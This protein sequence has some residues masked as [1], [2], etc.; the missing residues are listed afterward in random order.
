MAA[1]LR[2]RKKRATQDALS[3]AALDLALQKGFDAVT[4]EAI[5]ELAGVSTRT[6]HN[7]FSSKEAAVL[8]VLN[9]SIAEAIAMFVLRSPDEP[10]LDSMEAMQIN[11]VGSADGLER[12]VAVTRLMAESPALTAKHAATFDPAIDELLAEI[13]RRTGTDPDTDVYPRLVYHATGAIVRAALEIYLG[14]SSTGRD[15]PRSLLIDAIRD[16][17]AQLR[18]G[19]SQPAPGSGP[20]IHPR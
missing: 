16:G 5:A 18:R 7:Y 9:K 1:G 3:S 12:M 17:Y 2:E 4:A 13:G 8:F 6:F 14:H 20:G 11:F 15:H 10:I 19:L